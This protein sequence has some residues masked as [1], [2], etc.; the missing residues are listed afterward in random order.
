MKSWGEGGADRLS[1][2]I[3]VGFGLAYG[4]AG[5]F[6]QV[7]FYNGD[8][9]PHHW[10]YMVASVMVLLGFG[11]VLTKPFNL[12]PNGIFKLFISFKFKS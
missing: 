11:L 4:Y 1:A 3:I 8:I 7:G 9:G 12:K 10:I 5:K 2:L 6:I